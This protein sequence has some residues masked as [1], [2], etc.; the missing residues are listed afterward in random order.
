MEV[1]NSQHPIRQNGKSHACLTPEVNGGKHYAIKTIKF[2]GMKSESKKRIVDLTNLLSELNCQ[3]LVNL[4]SHSIDQQK[5]IL[6]LAFDDFDSTNLEQKIPILKEDEMWKIITRVA[7]SVYEFHRGCQ[8]PQWHGNIKTSNIFFDK[9]NDAK[10]GAFKSAREFKDG[11]DPI[12]KDLFEIG[13]VFFEMTTKSKLPN[14][15]ETNYAKIS[16]TS[17]GIQ[18]FLSR[19]ISTNPN[20]RMNIEEILSFLEISLEVM[21]EK[22]KIDQERLEFLKQSIKVK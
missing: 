2:C 22:V 3:Y 13:E 9:K 19:Q 18:S 10:L 14:S 15:K 8:R 12:E 16:K 5:G 7:L 11:E 20:E 21:R 1:F 6:S 4:E 17:E